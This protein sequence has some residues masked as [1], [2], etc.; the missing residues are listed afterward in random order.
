MEFEFNPRDVRRLASLADDG[1]LGLPE[2]QRNFIWRP[3]AIADLLRT[4]ARNWPA[5]SFLLLKGPQE[6]AC[7]PI[8]GAPP[9][10]REP[11]LLIL[12]GQQRIT[13]LYQA[14]GDQAP[15]TYYVD[16]RNLL[17]TGELD[18]EHVRYE[19]KT[20]FHKRFPST[21]AMATQ[22]IISVTAWRMIGSSIVG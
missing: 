20:K 21:E 15:E 8:Q 3:P 17:E 19:K 1:T 13:A 2:F 11:T 5:G 7:K 9:L 22:G 4:V 6:F 12:D 18:D 14:F 10:T 16:M